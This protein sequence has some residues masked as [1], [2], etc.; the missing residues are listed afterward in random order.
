MEEEQCAHEWKIIKEIKKK[1]KTILGQPY[2]D[3][4]Y[5]SQCKKCGKIKSERTQGAEAD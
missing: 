4:I 1:G 3:T 2:E 5:H